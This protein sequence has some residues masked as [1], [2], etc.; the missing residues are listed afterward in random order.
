MVNTNTRNKNNSKT[1]SRSLTKIDIEN[2]S[3]TSSSIYRAAI[4]LR[5]MTTLGY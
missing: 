4:Y 2:F 1:Y 5:E 3:A